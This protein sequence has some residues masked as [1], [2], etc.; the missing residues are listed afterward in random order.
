MKESS[1][2]QASSDTMCAI[3]PH[4]TMAHMLRPGRHGDTHITRESGKCH[5]IPLPPTT[6]PADYWGS[7]IVREQG[8]PNITGDQLGVYTTGT[9]KVQRGRVITWNIQT[10]KIENPLGAMFPEWNFKCFATFYGSRQIADRPECSDCC[11]EV[12]TF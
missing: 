8:G 5:L 2:G 6:S 4:T 9:L 10:V 12:N 3:V 11:L 1:F 7:T